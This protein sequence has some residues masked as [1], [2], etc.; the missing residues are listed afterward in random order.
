MKWPNPRFLAAIILAVL[1]ATAS[2]ADDK[3]ADRFQLM[4]VFGL[5]H[6]CS[7]VALMVSVVGPAAGTGRNE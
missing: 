3:P 2:P 7:P 1:A 6:A 4:D 5:E